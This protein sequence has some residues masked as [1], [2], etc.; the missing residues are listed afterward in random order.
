MKLIAKRPFANVKALSLKLDTKDDLYQHPGIVHKGARFTIGTGDNFAELPASDQE[1][2][3]TLVYRGLAILDND[4]NEK[5]GVIKTLDAEAKKEAAAHKAAQEK[6]A[7][8][9]DIFAKVLESNQQ[10][11]AALQAKPKG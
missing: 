1:T 10:V 6:P 8:L 9:L 5:T 11:L 3:G 2:I 7:S 4:E